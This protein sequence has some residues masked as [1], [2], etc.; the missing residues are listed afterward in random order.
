MKWHFLFNCRPI[1]AENQAVP[2]PHLF[3]FTNTISGP[4]TD[5]YLLDLKLKHFQDVIRQTT[6]DYRYDSSQQ[7]EVKMEPK[8][9]KNNIIYDTPEKL[10]KRVQNAQH[11]REYRKNL[12][13]NEKERRR[14]RAAQY[15]RDFRKNLPDVERQM[16]RRLDTERMRRFRSNLSEYEK[17]IR[18]QKAKERMR[19]QRELMRLQ[20]LSSVNGLQPLG[21]L[22]QI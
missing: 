18:K 3:P 5:S 10:E 1:K 20:S 15:M 2:I 17:E 13:D 14:L 16:R 19:K 22:T 11:M 6:P 7:S 9:K 8:R 12:P 4:S 21:E